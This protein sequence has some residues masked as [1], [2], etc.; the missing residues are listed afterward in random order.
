MV[1]TPNRTSNGPDACRW[2]GARPDA[3]DLL[4]A[5]F[6][7]AGTQA[8][9]EAASGPFYRSQATGSCF[10]GYG[11]IFDREYPSKAPWQKERE[12][13]NTR[14]RGVPAQFVGTPL[15]VLTT[16]WWARLQPFGHPGGTSEGK[17]KARILR[18]KGALAKGGA[19]QGAT[20]LANLSETAGAEVERPTLNSAR[21]Q[22]RRG[23][24]PDL[25]IHDP[26]S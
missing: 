26:R 9:F 5:P 22:H 14:H 2:C 18:R 17:G 19:P 21:S 16:Q 3:S 11:G 23:R 24:D 6:A 1:L 8:G 12:G 7:S 10:G 20:N 15:R 4:V 13:L 25:R